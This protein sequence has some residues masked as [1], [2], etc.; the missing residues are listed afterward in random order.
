MS[1]FDNKYSWSPC[2]HVNYRRQS[3]LRRERKWRQCHTS[4]TTRP[5]LTS[6]HCNIG[7][8]SHNLLH[9]TLTRK[10][11]D[12]RLTTAA[13]GKC[14]TSHHFL[15]TC[16]HPKQRFFVGHRSKRVRFTHCL[17]QGRWFM[18]YCKDTNSNFKEVICRLYERIM[19]RSKLPPRVPTHGILSKLTA[20]VPITHGIVK[21]PKNYLPMIS[22]MFTLR[23][24]PV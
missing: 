12:P 15:V 24:V 6:Y 19:Q 11:R 10:R 3:S 1:L 2:C 7:G 16:R 23:Y 14:G 18:I 20:D 9:P 17:L 5:W 22:W 8:T 13:I 21:I 4:T